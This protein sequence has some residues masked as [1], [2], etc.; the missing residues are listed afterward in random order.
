LKFTFQ[1][2]LIMH[3]KKWWW[4]MCQYD[5]CIQGWIKWTRGPGQNH[6]SEAP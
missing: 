5:S 4:Y 3:R 2:N 1:L 6:D